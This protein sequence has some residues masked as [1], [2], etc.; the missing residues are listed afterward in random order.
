MVKSGPTPLAAASHR[1][2]GATSKDT[3]MLIDSYERH[4]FRLADVSNIANA[5][6]ALA[7][8]DEVREAVYLDP[9][10]IATYTPGH[11]KGK[12]VLIHKISELASHI[13]LCA[14]LV[15]YAHSI[16]LGLRI[17]NNWPTPAI[18]STLQDTDM[19]TV[20]GLS[21]ALTSRWVT[22][23]P[24][25]SGEMDLFEVVGDEC[26]R[27]AVIEQRIGIISAVL[28]MCGKGDRDTKPNA[29]DT[30][31]VATI[32]FEDGDRV[33]G[34][35]VTPG[36]E[37]RVTSECIKEPGRGHFAISRAVACAGAITLEVGKVSNTSKWSVQS[38]AASILS[39]WLKQFHTVEATLAKL[40]VIGCSK[41]EYDAILEYVRRNGGVNDPL[42]D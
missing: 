16:K 22:H 33:Q 3:I 23:Q 4:M 40:T 14:H 39:E 32:R 21:M 9:K 2:L 42:L 37:V 27:P 36:Q 12:H 29:P 10:K 24:A 8:S 18:Y 6:A 5:R 19:D 13:D 25:R 28:S 17:E 35:T 41:S 20:R 26:E 30:P 38:W 11:F 15:E 1:L 34:M 31:M 7:Y